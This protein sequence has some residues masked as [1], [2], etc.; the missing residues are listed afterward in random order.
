RGPWMRRPSGVRAPRGACPKAVA[1]AA[2]N[3]TNVSCGSR[4][5]VLA[6]RELHKRASTSLGRVVTR[7]AGICFGVISE[8]ARFTVYDP[9]FPVTDRL[10]VISLGVVKFPR[11][12][13]RNALV[14]ELAKTCQHDF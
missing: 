14:P 2:I 12:Q 9:A 11:F 4:L 6:A 8:S 7:H 3:T 5:A 13:Q 1:T 10:D